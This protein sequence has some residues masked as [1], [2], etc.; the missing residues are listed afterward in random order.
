MTI[1]TVNA[2]GCVFMALDTKVFGIQMAHRLPVG[3]INGMAL[4]TFF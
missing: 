2:Y 4:H 1:K 3:I